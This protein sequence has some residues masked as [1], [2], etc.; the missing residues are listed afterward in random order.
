MCSAEGRYADRR[1]RSG[2]A[3][4][5]VLVLAL[6][7]ACGRKQE[8][9]KTQLI[10]TIQGSE[11]GETKKTDLQ[12]VPDPE[13]QVNGFRFESCDEMV[14]CIGEGVKLRDQPGLDGEEVGVLPY[15]AYVQRIGKNKRWSRILVNGLRVYAAA[16]YLSAYPPETE[17]EETKETKPEGSTETKPEG[18][19]ETKAERS[20]E[21]KAER[22]VETKA[23][24]S[25]ETKAEGSAKTKTEGSTEIKAA[26]SPEAKAASFCAKRIKEIP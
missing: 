22:S 1:K 17:A 4:G 5:L 26:G 16:E 10:L 14:Y 8:T 13:D 24:R 18:S 3:L 2:A 15:G 6:L 23:E 25:T 20:A 11:A 19:T 7:C 12:A 9:E 21:T